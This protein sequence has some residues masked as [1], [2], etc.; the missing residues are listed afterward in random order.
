MTE[1]RI[2]EY[3]LPEAPA[4]NYDELKNAITE[5]TKLYKTMV[6]GEDQIRQAKADRAELNRISKALND[7]R[8]AMEREYNA[9]F[10]EFKTKVNEIISIIKEAS[11]AIDEQ[12]KAFELREKEA[13]ELACHQ[14][15]DCKNT[16][17]WLKYEQVANATWTNKS[18]SMEKIADD[19]DIALAAIGTSLEALKGQQ[20]EFEATEYYKKTLSLTG[21]LDEN[22]RLVE[23][24]KKKAEAEARAEEQRK[25]EELAKAEREKRE[26]EEAEKATKEKEEYETPIIEEVKTE[27]PTKVERYW[28]TFHIK[29]SPEEF[30]L[31]CEHMTTMGLEWKVEF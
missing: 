4:F 29:M 2:E 14:L 17:D 26:A 31:L 12:V 8:I 6:Y 22:R 13:K 10:T 19:I 1:L 25:A 15:F 20:Y 7:K 5:S 30:D 3:K 18:T 21:A 16:Y 27:Q 28:S 24:A 11:G 23:L 9:P